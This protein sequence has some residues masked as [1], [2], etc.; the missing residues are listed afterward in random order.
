MDS[1]DSKII[2]KCTESYNLVLVFC[3]I[4]FTVWYYMHCKKQ[5][6]VRWPVLGMLPWIIIN[7]HRIHDWTVDI[8]K[9]FGGTVIER[10]PFFGRLEIVYTCDPRN[11][12]Y[13]LATNYYNFNDRQDYRD[14][15]DILGDGLLTA[16]S[17]FWTAQRR[18][19]RMTFTSKIVRNIIF[20]KGTKVTQHALLPLLSHLSKESSGVDLQDVLMSFPPNELA[21]AMD[22]ASEAIL[23]RH[24]LPISWWK[25][26]RRLKIG[27]NEKKLE[28]AGKIIDRNIAE[29]IKV[30]REEM[31]AKGSKADKYEENDLL[32]V[33][34][35]IKDGEKDELMLAKMLTDKFF[36]DTC[37]TFLIAA[38]DTTASTLSWFFWMIL[39][40]PSVEA[41]ILEE[42]ELIIS[43]KNTMEKNPVIFDADD[44]TGMVYLH[45]A[46]CESL[47]LYPAVPLLRKTSTSDDVFPDGTVIWPGMTVI[48]SC[49]AMGRMEWVW[50]ED[51]LEFKPERWISEDGKLNPEALSKLVSFSL[52][53]RN[54]VGKDMAFVLMK[55]VASAVIYN[56]H[57]EVLEGQNIVPTPAITL[58]MMNGLMV[59]VRGR[60]FP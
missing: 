7:A 58:K 48:I 46:L 5:V 8:S 11:A 50:G 17:N 22:N 57:V 23:F 6:I 51:C 10:G 13:I 52:G 35:S 24:V 56:Y 47:R 36:R 15:F 29:Y 3:L 20:H 53:P 30:K 59:R 14:A 9:I 12:K 1:H 49:Y 27:S 39:K 38:R 44:Q 42:L 55:L 18:A 60:V 16:T 40:N 32:E 28:A 26:S 43:K 19:A 4:L 41:K 21:E 33:Y 37:I 45:A 25:L 34:M 2:E 31:V 54:C